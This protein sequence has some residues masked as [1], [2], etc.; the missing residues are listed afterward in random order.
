MGLYN[1]VRSYV[2]SLSLSLA[3]SS[4]S[5]RQSIRSVADHRP[6][7][8]QRFASLEPRSKLINFC[9]LSR[10]GYYYYSLCR[11]WLAHCRFQ[12]VCQSRRFV[13]FVLYNA[14]CFN[15]LRDN[16]FAPPPV[17]SLSRAEPGEQSACRSNCN[18]SCRSSQTPRHRTRNRSRRQSVTC[19]PNR[20]FVFMSICD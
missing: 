3:S 4:M 2:N 20:Y 17:R 19:L 1:F 15:Y 14:K 12:R 7:H 13:S 9:C 5:E 11:C 10:F 8:A 18:R 16:Y 6:S